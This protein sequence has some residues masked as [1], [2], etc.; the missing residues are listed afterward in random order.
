[1]T[2]RIPAPDDQ[3]CPKCHAVN[4]PGVEYVWRIADE[5]GLHLEC[6]VC[7]HSWKP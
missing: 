2:V 7:A 6:I 3:P 1:M 4:R 5:R